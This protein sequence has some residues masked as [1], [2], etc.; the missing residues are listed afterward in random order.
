MQMRFKTAGEILFGCGMLAEL[1]RVVQ[2]L[3]GTRCFIVSDQGLAAA[4]MV[5]RVAG[6]LSSSGIASEIYADTGS[7]PSIENASDCAGK[8]RSSGADLV[9]GLGGGS[10]MDV[11]KISAVA[12]RHG[13]EV[14][15]YIG[16][17]MV[18]GRGFPTVLLPTTAGTGSEATPIVVLS[19]RKE[20]LKKGVV[21]RYLYADVAL[22]DPELTVSVPP[23]VTAFTGMDA[24]A[25]A[26][27]VFTNK[28]AVPL[29]D[30]LTSRAAGL[31]VRNLP[32]AVRDGTLLAAR[33]A[34]AH[35]S[36]MAGMCLGPVNTAATHALAYP[37]GGT[38]DVPHGVANAL[39][40]PHVMEFNLTVIPEKCR[41]LAAALGVDVKE[42]EPAE[43]A[44]R[45]SGAVKEL[46]EGIGLVQRMR[47]LDIP[48]EAIPEMAEA[49]MKVTRL[50]GNNPRP[51]SREDAVA[52][53]ENAY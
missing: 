26:V 17:D 46:S 21:S 23:R 53:Y 43:A 45:C 14:S 15:G 8:C 11:A 41:E 20:H 33:S 47:E 6:L 19:D 10:P 50:L 32:A 30:A 13:G 28:H 39:L 51:V 5:D 3:G 2:R 34:M 38:F 4:G 1:P 16:I 37:L 12:A 18:P 48:R 42:M 25:H 7:D 22:V 24:L 27:E 40:L 29:A 44:A 49:A 36:L 35:A 31:I 9:I 52:I